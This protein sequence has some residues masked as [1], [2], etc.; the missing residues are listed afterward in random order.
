[1][2]NLKLSFSKVYFY[3]TA[4]LIDTFFPSALRLAF[5][6]AA[7]HLAFFISAKLHRKM[8]SRRK[9]SDIRSELGYCLS[10]RNVGRLAWQCGF[11]CVEDIIWRF[12]VKYQSSPAKM[13]V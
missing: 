6:L 1:M 9:M 12:R 8:L 13:S 10:I 4:R 5:L 7:L 2:P 11:S 3:R